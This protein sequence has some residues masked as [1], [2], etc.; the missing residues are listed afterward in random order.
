MPASSAA[1]IWSSAGR[2]KEKSRMSASL[3]VPHH[4]NPRRGRG[5]VQDGKQA[6]NH[7]RR[8]YLRGEAHT[9]R[10]EKRNR[11]KQERKGQGQRRRKT[12]G[13]T[14]KRGS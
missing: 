12:E 11:E 8:V 13:E 1:G 4:S 14:A 7:E 5:N 3:L 9:V 2:E 10:V 6:N